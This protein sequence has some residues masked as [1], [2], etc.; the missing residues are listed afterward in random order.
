MEK[1]DSIKIEEAVLN[2]RKLN[3]EYG[4]LALEMT[5]A[6][7]GN[8][9][10][11]DLYVMATINR[12]ENLVSAFCDLVERRMFLRMQLDNLFR[13]RAAW[14]VDDINNFVMEV[15]GGTAISKL[16]DRNGNKM[17]DWYLVDSLCK[18]YPVLKNFQISIFLVRL[19]IWVPMRKWKCT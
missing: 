2:I 12:S 1:E 4:S 8:M 14:L 15:L 3:A 19:K 10:L 13:L 5:K 7:N 17:A 18:E 6:C 11:M 16:K 9:Y